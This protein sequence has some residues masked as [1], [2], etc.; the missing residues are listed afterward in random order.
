V[1]LANSFSNDGFD[2]F[3]RLE[4]LERRLSQ[5]LGYPVDVVAEPARKQRFQ[6]EID[7]DRTLAF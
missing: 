6:H 4:Q 7:K 3:Y 2:Y 1:R 5:L